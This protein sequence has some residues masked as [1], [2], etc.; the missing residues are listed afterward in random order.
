[1]LTHE[2]DS[3][4]ANQAAEEKGVKVFAY[5]SDESKYGPKAQ[6]GGTILTWGDYYTKVVGDV[7]AGQ[8]KSGSVW[9]GLKD[10]FIKMGPMSAAVPKDVQAMVKQLEAQ[11]VAGKLHPFTGPMVDQDGKVRVP[12]GQTI[13]DHDLEKMDY[14]VQGV[15]SKLPGK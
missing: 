2:T 3:A 10:G 5:N 1:M 14:Y 8:W 13:S 11:I 4:A 15:A 9:G 6:V 12:A 7:L